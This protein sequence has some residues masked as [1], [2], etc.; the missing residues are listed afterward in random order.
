MGNTYLGI[1]SLKECEHIRK[2][3]VKSVN[4]VAPTC[5][6]RW[7]LFFWKGEPIGW[8]KTCPQEDFFNLFEG[9]GAWF[10]IK[11][12]CSHQNPFVLI[13][14]PNN[15]HQ[16]PL[17]P[18]NNQSKSFCSQKVL[19]KFFLLPSNSQKVLI[20]FLLFPSIPFCYHQVPKQFFLF[21]S[22]SFC[23]HGYGG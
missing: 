6:Q 17:V 15:S 4:W 5:L 14:F 1:L 12:S 11:S 22:K 3:H 23:S 2:K 13:K 9:V 10:P 7:F 18:I 19:I 8:R 20:K 21:P 16:I